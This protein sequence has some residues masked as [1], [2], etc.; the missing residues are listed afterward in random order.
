M[1][2]L[3]SCIVP[4][5]VA[6]GRNGRKDGDPGTGTALGEVVRRRRRPDRDAAAARSGSRDQ[7]QLRPAQEPLTLAEPEADVVMLAEMLGE[8]G[9]VPGVLIVAQRARGSPQ[10]L[11]DFLPIHRGQ[12]ARTAGAGAFPQRAA[13]AG[14][15]TMHPPLDRGRML[16]QPRGHRRTRVALAYQ[17]HPV[18]PMI[19]PRFHRAADLLLQGD[20]RRL[21]IGD[22]QCFH[23][24]T[25]REQRNNGKRIMPHH[26]CRQGNRRRRQRRRSRSNP[27]KE[28]TF[29]AAN[30][31]EIAEAQPIC[32]QFSFWLVWEVWSPPLLAC[33]RP[34]PR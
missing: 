11:R 29:M 13:A 15:K 4:A 17:Q 14:G 34:Q 9:A 33:L 3:N 25:V 28:G 20:P 7:P 23:A 18:Q 19:I 21:R 16:A 32:R 30:G 1:K 2:R 10:F 12:P 31:P 26:F 6:A 27:S 24:P 8:Q 5:L 22:S